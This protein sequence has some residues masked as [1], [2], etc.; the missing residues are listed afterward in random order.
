V[1]HAA[2]HPASLF[3]MVAAILFVAS[4]VTLGALAL[5]LA[6]EAAF[7]AIAPRCG[8][9]RR[10]VQRSR[11]D[12][13]RAAARRRRDA[14][15]LEMGE[16]HRKELAQIDEL[17]ADALANAERRRATVTLGGRDE[18]AMAQLTLGYIHL[19]VHHRS[20]VQALVMTNIDELQATIRWLQDAVVAQRPAAQAMFR[21]RLAVATRRAERW[22]ETR[23]SL[24]ACAQQLATI[25]EL[26][27]LVHQESIDASSQ[28]LS[29]E[30]DRVLAD[31]EH[32][33]RAAREVALI[34]LDAQDGA[35]IEHTTVVS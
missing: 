22:M 26:A 3:I 30:V 18:G 31:F 7:L 21:R 6:A 4:H 25:A 14:L 29:A 1:A 28:A 33:D 24:E 12:E 9:F 20:F 16:V 8:A 10:A 11:A 35:D 27:C 13:E 34:G 2:I 23:V 15:I 17:L 5:G 19:A 32:G